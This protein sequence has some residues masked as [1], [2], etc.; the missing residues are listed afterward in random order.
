MF[1]LL[2]L[3]SGLSGRSRTSES[4]VSY[5]S[6]YDHV[7]VGISYEPLHFTAAPPPYSP[8]DADVPPPAYSS[9]TNINTLPVNQQSDR[10]VINS[11]CQAS[12]FDSMYSFTGYTSGCISAPNTASINS[13]T[14]SDCKQ[15]FGEPA[16]RPQCVGG[17]DTLDKSDKQAGTLAVDIDTATDTSSL[18]LTTSSQYISSSDSQTS[19]TTTPTKSP[20]QPI[21]TLSPASDVTSNTL[22]QYR[23]KA[24]QLPKRPEPIGGELPD[25]KSNPKLS[26]TSIDQSAAS[27]SRAV[28]SA[29]NS[30]LHSSHRNK[31]NSRHSMTL[32]Q[33]GY[34]DSDR[35]LSSSADIGPIVGISED[36]L[37]EIAACKPDRINARIRRQARMKQH[38][39]NNID[40]YP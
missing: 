7:D 31:R 36:C 6:A 35:A 5:S 4:S 2:F 13:Y 26:T 27:C 29:D 25:T 15:A 10:G 30:P 16:K 12:P 34:I 11:G 17:A 8:T 21:T 22:S 14:G 38:K 19:V 23:V 28:R 40:Q 9:I 3:V 39:D 37:L 33:Y 32:T 18:Q 24:K 1:T 20:S